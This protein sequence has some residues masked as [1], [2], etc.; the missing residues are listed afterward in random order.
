MQPVKYWYEVLVLTAEKLYVEGTLKV[1]HTPIMFSA[2]AHCIHTEPLHPSGAE[3]TGVKE[4]GNPPLY[5]NTHLNAGQIRA[6][7]RS[8]LRKYDMVP[9]GVLLLPGE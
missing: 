6:N 4:I 2:S 8:L 1:D 5:V 7:A 3:F 9:S